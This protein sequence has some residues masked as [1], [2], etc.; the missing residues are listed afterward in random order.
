LIIDGWIE[1]PY[2]QTMF[3]AWQAKAAYSAPTIEALDQHGQWHLVLEQFGYPA[4]MPRQM[5]VPLPAD[6]LP[7]GCRQLRIRTNQEIYFDR[8]AIALAEAGVHEARHHELALKHAELIQSGFALRTTG[9]QRQP[10]YDYDQRTPFWDTRYQRGS[11]TALG[12]M[13]ELIARKDDALAI[14]GPGEEVHMEFLADLPVLPEGWT[15]VFVVEVD[16]WCKDMDLY[17][18]DGETIDPLPRSEAGQ[19][20]SAARETLHQRYNTRFESGR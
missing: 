20:D 15:R 11:Y 8:I 13:T 10:S 1:Y 5:S 3:G 9:G 6:K 16:G 2:S 18:K 12:P 19:V 17:T 14:F 4:G 7:E